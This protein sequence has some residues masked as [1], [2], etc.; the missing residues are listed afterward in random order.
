MVNGKLTKAEKRRRAQ[1]SARDRSSRTSINNQRNNSLATTQTHTIMTMASIMPLTGTA[2]KPI[3]SWS[4]GPDY[5]PALKLAL[6]GCVSW[7]IRSLQAYI[8]P[9]MPDSTPAIIGILACPE[10]WSV[11]S[12]AE[13]Q[14]CGGTIAKSTVAKISSNTMG[15]ETTWRP[16]IE[17]SPYEVYYGC[18]RTPATPIEIGA[19]EFRIVIETRGISI[20]A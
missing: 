5:I 18:S 13:L 2:A 8:V 12:L 15:A 6:S 20:P 1:Q 10:K 17:R 16:K 11:N 4:V 9:T 7:R 3:I 14:A 19:M